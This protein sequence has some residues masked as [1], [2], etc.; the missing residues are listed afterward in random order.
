MEPVLPSWI[1]A[2]E[3]GEIVIPAE[4]IALS[5]I[6][7]DESFSLG[8][9]RTSISLRQ[10]GEW[11]CISYDDSFEQDPD[12]GEIVYY[13]DGKRARFLSVNIAWDNGTH[14][15][16]DYYVKLIEWEEGQRVKIQV[17]DEGNIKITEVEDTD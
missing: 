4:V 10:E 1:V 11:K 17:S 9:G 14:I 13:E 15:I 8:V 6:H 16:I 3:D 2:V 12:T 7:E 5:G